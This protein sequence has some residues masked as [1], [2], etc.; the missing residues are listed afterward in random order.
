[1]SDFLKRLVVSAEVQAMQAHVRGDQG[2]AAYLAGAA[3]V[4]R[5]CLAGG[6][7]PTATV[8]QEAR[9][10]QRLVNTDL[11]PKRLQGVTVAQLEELGFRFYG[12]EDNLFYRAE[13]PEGWEKRPSD[14]S[15]WSYI[16]DAQG[17]C[18][19][20]VFYK[21]A[22]YDR[23]AHMGLN[24]RFSCGTEPVGGWENRAEGTA[25]V[26]VV[27][28]GERALFTTD[29]TEPEPNRDASQEE[30]MTWYAAKD[31][32]GAEAEAWLTE[33][34]PDWQSAFAYWE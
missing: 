13:L 26:G 12:E 18:R 6:D 3:E 33:R 25:F 5:E 14:H 15:M 9:G 28:D 7:P 17:R 34:Y 31:A 20:S 8:R 1:M 24:R 2:D 10:Q 27:K 19:A 16:H 23:D 11:I 32:K 22:F 29:P 4:L 30:W 21:A